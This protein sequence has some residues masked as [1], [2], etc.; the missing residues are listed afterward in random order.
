MTLSIILGRKHTDS[1]NDFSVIAGP[2]AP[3]DINNQFNQLTLSD[4][5]GL[6]EIYLHEL[7]LSAGRKRKSFSPAA[8][9]P[10]DEPARSQSEGGSADDDDEAPEIDLPPAPP[11]TRSKSKKSSSPRRGRSR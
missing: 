4:G 7:I 1:P 2:G 5:N 8:S 9:Q 3:S 10:P 6:A 11:A